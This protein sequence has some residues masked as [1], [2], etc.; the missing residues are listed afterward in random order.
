[1][2]S[3]QPLAKRSAEA[4]LPGAQIE[5]LGWFHGG[6]ELLYWPLGHSKHC[7]CAALVS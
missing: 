2:Q 5:H 3:V 4:S 1:M 7:V 6:P